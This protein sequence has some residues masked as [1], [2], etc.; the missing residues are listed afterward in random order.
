MDYYA[1]Y[2]YLPY[3]VKFTDNSGKS[4]SSLYKNL[5]LKTAAGESI[6]LPEL[7][8]VKNMIALGWSTTANDTVARAKAGEKVRITANTT[9]YAVYR[10]PQKKTV[11]FCDTNGSTPQAFIALKTTV[12]EGSSIMLPDIPEK[13]GYFPV[14]WR[15]NVNG[16]IRTY[17][18]GTKIFVRGNYRFYAFYKQ[19]VQIILH[20]ND[21][22]VYKTEFSGKGLE[23]TLPSMENPSGY[24]F[25]GWGTKS[26]IT[27]SQSRPRKT[28]YEPDTSVVVN[29]T[30]HFYA[31]LM[32]RSEEPNL[33]KDQLQGSSS[34]DTSAYKR[35]IFVGDS[36]TTRLKLFLTKRGIDFSSKKVSF[37]QKGGSS[38]EWLESTG[39]KQIL[40]I[41]AKDGTKDT[42][43]TAII[44][45]SGI[46]GLN[47]YGEY[48]SFYKKI[49]PELREKNC[50]LYIMSINPI[51][52]VM[53][54]KMNF[55]RRQPSQ[56]RTFNEY[57]RTNL[58]GL[59]TYIDTYTWLM[60]TG[61]ST[62]RGD[63]GY[64]TGVD[65]GLHYT[66]RTYQRIYFRCLQFLAG[67]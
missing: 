27:L 20:Y 67:S 33:S 61:F 52:S 58:S 44:F 65:D 32:K 42:R 18:A 12:T 48:V 50:R 5:N 38:I 13:E 39:Y 11:M 28:Y 41:I 8:A 24:T 55:I 37:V 31:I 59:Y 57:L 21:G 14:C 30:S 66:L 2:V 56:L 40:D 49:A 45:N 64:D 34:P 22:Q 25:M 10:A 19:R 26:G 43:P 54:E 15:L 3:T 62:D 1:K 16:T 63:S 35:I 23:Y 4:T 60:Q 6:T 51:N 7:P 53:I 17:D 46:N 29:G 47:D 36:R 9:Y